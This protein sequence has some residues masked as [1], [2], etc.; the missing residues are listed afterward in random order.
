MSTGKEM[1]Y[2]CCVA[3]NGHL[4]SMAANGTGV[5]EDG[6]DRPEQVTTETGT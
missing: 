4:L 5:D 2:V 1:K 6:F 3:T